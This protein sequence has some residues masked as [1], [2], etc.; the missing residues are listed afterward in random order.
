MLNVLLT[1][2]TEISFR[3]PGGVP[4]A[5]ARNVDRDLYGRTPR[6][7]FG[8]PFQID[9]L[10]AHGLKAVYFVE[11]LFSTVLGPEPLRRIVHCVQD[12][13]HEVQ[14]HLHPEW[15]ARMPAPPVPGRDRRNLKDFTEDEQVTLLSRGLELL[16]SA[17]ARNVT[18]FRAGNYGAG[19]ET[20]R[21]LARVGLRYD[22]S[23]NACYLDSDCGLR[24]PEP[25]LQPRTF[26]AV[27]EVP[28][29]FFGDWPGHHRH[30]QLT[31]CSAAELENV[32]TQAWRAGWFCVVVVWHSYELV[33]RDKESGAPA[34]PDP[35][36]L[37]R[38]RRLCEFLDRRRDRFRTVTFAD[39]AAEGVPELA[40]ARPL[41]SRVGRTAW[42]FVEQLARKVV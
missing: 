32:L 12:G 13:G 2:D 35:I 27:T 29:T 25:L 34:V 33:R 42:R 17:G 10:N 1:V 41:R 22:T 9:R 37:R 6:G 38:F 5:L 16:R 11:S 28:I 3:A 15:L 14:L 36:V 23:Y 31:A 18:A 4:A 24:G 21:A 7:D 40:P 20:L 26:G 39:L 30:A 8:V 19:W